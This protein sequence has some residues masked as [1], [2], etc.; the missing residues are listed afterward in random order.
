M[1]QAEFDFC[2]RLCKYV[3]SR[4]LVSINN[5]SRADIV[6]ARIHCSSI[7][8]QALCLF[9]Y[10]IEHNLLLDGFMKEVLK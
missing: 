4:Y 6:Y 1:T 5:N 10:C 8:V 9:E 3:K 7:S 2:I